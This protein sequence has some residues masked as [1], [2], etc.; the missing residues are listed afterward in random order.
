MPLPLKKR[1]RVGGSHPETPF[2]H[3]CYLGFTD[4]CKAAGYP[5]SGSSSSSSSGSSGGSGSSGSSGSS[6][7]GSATGAASLSTAIT[8]SKSSATLVGVSVGFLGAVVGLAM[9]GLSL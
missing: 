6:A 4:G 8:G 2:V 9:A 3:H 5:I 1:Y 7:S